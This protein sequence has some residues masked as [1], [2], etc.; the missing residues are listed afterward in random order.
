[1]YVRSPPGKSLTY[2][3][4]LWP[5]GDEPGSWYNVEAF[6]LT[7]R[8]FGVPHF[9]IE[10]EDW[11]VT[12]EREKVVLTAIEAVLVLSSFGPS[13]VPPREDGYFRA[14]FRGVQYRLSD[15]GPY[16]GRPSAM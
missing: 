10:A 14:T 3:Y 4:Q 11:A 13:P 2:D 15:F 1:L 16:F 5:P 8:S 12:A 6:R 9:E 7:S